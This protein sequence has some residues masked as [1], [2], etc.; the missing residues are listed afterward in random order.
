[1][2]LD[3]NKRSMRDMKQEGEKFYPYRHFNGLN[4]PITEEQLLRMLAA[5]GVHPDKDGDLHWEDILKAA[6]DN[7]IR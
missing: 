1:M 7:G 6:E 4:K 5:V 2:S 3:K